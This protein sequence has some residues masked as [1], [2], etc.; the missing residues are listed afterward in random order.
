VVADV[1]AIPADLC[2]KTLMHQG[3]EFGHALARFGDTVLP[4]LPRWLR[5]RE[6]IKDR[7]THCPGCGEPWT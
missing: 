4:T 2:R 5:W 1:E 6:P 7:V 3:Q